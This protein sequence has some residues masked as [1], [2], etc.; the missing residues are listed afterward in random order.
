MI[1]DL[2][3]A[4]VR[5]LADE[6]GTPHGLAARALADGHRIRR[7]RRTAT[8]AAALAA[9]LAVTVPI[10]IARTP[11]DETRPLPAATVTVAPAPAFKQTEVFTGP[12]GVP[13]LSIEDRTKT[14]VLN[15]KTGGYREL[16]AGVVWIEPSPDGRRAVVGR[17]N[18][19]KVEILDLRT[20]ESW[21]TAVTRTSNVSWSG[22]GSRVLVSHETGYSIIEPARRRSTDRTIEPGQL[23]CLEFCEF[24]W[25]AGDTRIALPQVSKLGEQESRVSGVATFEANSGTVIEQL[26]IKALPID[27]FSASPDGRLLLTRQNQSPEQISMIEIA[28]Q[29][30]IAHFSVAWS[31]FLADGTVLAQNGG[32]LT[33]YAATG[34]VLEKV[35]LPPELTGRHLTFGL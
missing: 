3:R 28:S 25:F 17:E 7:N 13:L 6:S 29:R 18:S 2:L 24:T 32:I 31:Q 1:D 34:A 33:R 5:D 8:V 4:T 20:G 9:V 30:E 27:Q 12:G 35:A 14:F 10:V 19:E 22:D 21:R 15:P 16:P 26:P 11:A 23:A